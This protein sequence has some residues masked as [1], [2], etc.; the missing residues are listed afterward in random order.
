MLNRISKSKTKISPYEIWK[1][2]KPNL[3]YLRTWGCLDYVIILD[4]KRNKLPSRAYECVLIGYAF[5]S[6]T[7]RFFDLKDRVIIESNDVEF[8]EY[9]F[10]FKLKNSGGTTPSNASLVRISEPEEVI[11]IEPMRSIRARTMTGWV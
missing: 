3:S 6:K 7:Y 8:Y 10:P 11:K 9:K 2:R 4:Y 1:N 5:N